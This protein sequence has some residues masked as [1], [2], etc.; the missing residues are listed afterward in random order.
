MPFRSNLPPPHFEHTFTLSSQLI[1]LFEGEETAQI[2]KHLELI[3]GRITI[4]D[5]V[6]A[7]NKGIAYQSK[8]IITA[9]Y[10]KT[11]NWGIKTK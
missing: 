11:N 3:H 8:L 4:I 10:S 1:S 2:I 5:E 9:F 7:S 6:D